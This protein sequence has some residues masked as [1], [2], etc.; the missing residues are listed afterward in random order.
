MTYKIILIHTL[1]FMRQCIRKPRVCRC[2]CVC[3]GVYIYIYIN[4]EILNDQLWSISAYLRSIICKLIIVYLNI[5][6]AFL[7]AVD[8]LLHSVIPLSHSW[9]Q[10]NFNNKIIINLFQ[11]NYMY[12][13]FLHMVI[14]YTTITPN[15]LNGLYYLLSILGVVLKRLR[16]A[17]GRSRRLNRAAV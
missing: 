9:F 16:T 3:I 1:L 12:D 14:L 8:Q 15:E 6:K 10:H 11:H 5:A 13:Y 17:P 2:V 4:I 7:N